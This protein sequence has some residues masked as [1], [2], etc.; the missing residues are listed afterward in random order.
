MIKSDYIV[1]DCETGGLDPFKNPITQYAAVILDGKTLKE[2]DRFETFVKPYADL[3]IERSAL[4]ATM[5]S[6][7]DINRGMRVDDFVESVTGWWESHRQKARTKDMGRLVPVG[8]NVTF[9]IGFLNVALSVCE[10]PTVE[11]WIYPNL[12]DTYSLGKMM[13]GVNGDEKL[14]LSA[15]CE[16]AKILL[17]DAHGAMNDVEATADLF[18]WFVKRMRRKSGNDGE[19]RS[20]R[21]RG[22][23]FFEFRC[24]G[25]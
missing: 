24:G 20:G 6:M 12:I 13:W 7:S 10:K 23:E 19:E 4:D 3:V 9:D 5:V 25:K 22:Q 1:F 17:S 18:R 11:N 21:E 8:H 16:R 15:C 14:T 2:T